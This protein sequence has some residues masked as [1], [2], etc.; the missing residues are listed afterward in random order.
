[1]LCFPIS[2]WKQPRKLNGILE[3]YLLYISSHMLDFTIWDV[4]YNSTELFQDHTLQYLLPGTKY[5]LKLGVSLLYSIT[6]SVPFLSL[7]LPFP[8][9]IFSPSLT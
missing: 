7:L 3:R 5:L 4:V 9:P 8:Y 2:R 1:M 6:F